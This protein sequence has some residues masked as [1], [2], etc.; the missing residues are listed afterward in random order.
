MENEDIETHQI[1]LFVCSF[2]HDLFKDVRRHQWRHHVCVCVCWV[3]LG[4]VPVVGRANM[5]IP[6]TGRVGVPGRICGVQ[7]L[8]DLFVYVVVID[9][10]CVPREHHLSANVRVEEALG[11]GSGS[12]TPQRYGSNLE[13]GRCSRSSTLHVVKTI[14]GA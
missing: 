7:I 5:A 8:P 14:S 2:V 4:C 6:G 10:K 9:H 13:F 11:R 3:G 12:G 1:K